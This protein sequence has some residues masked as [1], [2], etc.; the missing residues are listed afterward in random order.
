[1]K[2]DRERDWPALQK[3]PLH[4]DPQNLQGRTLLITGGN[5]GIGLECA[6]QLAKMSPSKIIL[7]CRNMKTAA[8]AVESIKAGGFN[9]VEAWHLDQGSISSVKAFT[10]RYN[11]SGLDLHLVLANAGLLSFKSTPTPELT[12]EGHELMVATNHSG[13]VLLTLGLLPSL[14]RT[15]AKASGDQLPRIVIVSSDVHYWTELSVSKE[16]GNMIKAMDSQKSWTNNRDRYFDTK[17][18][19]MLYAQELGKK[20]QQSQVKEDKKI[21][22]AV[23]N[24]GLVLSREQIEDPVSPL[25]AERRAIARDYTEGC[26]THLFASI[27]PSTAKPTEVIYY[28]NCRPFEAAD[29]TLG[30]EGEALRKRVWQD[31]LEVLGVTEQDF[32]L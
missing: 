6:K 22:V 24:P 27:D 11:D 12:E 10:N 28:T 2:L 20:L 13:A 15:A 14:R 21:V 32:Q 3:E 7:A 31:T 23:V 30:P 17:L 26:K 18:L 9:N 5:A 8:E 4:L 1:M 16:Q 29:I 19:N 25:P